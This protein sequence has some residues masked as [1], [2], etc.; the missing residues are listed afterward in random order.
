MYSV[1]LRGKL[2][3][4][5]SEQDGTVT[6]VGSAKEGEGFG[7]TPILHGKIGVNVPRG[8]G[9]GFGSGAIHGAAVLEPD[10]GLPDGANG[11]DP[12]YDGAFAELPG[13]GAAPGEAGDVGHHV[14]GVDARVAQSGFGGQRA[15]AQ[16]RENLRKL[17]ELALR[18]GER[19]KTRE[20]LD[21]VKGCWSTR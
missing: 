10:V 21:C 4:E 5:R 19:P 20:Q 2:R 6:V 3:A 16:L 17:Q 8:G 11:C 13:G 12:G 1:V 18:M 14:R 7:E 9:T 15:A